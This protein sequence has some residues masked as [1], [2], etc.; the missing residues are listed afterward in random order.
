[1]GNSPYEKEIEIFCKRVVEKLRPRSV[2]LFGSI[3]RR[4]YGPWS[5]VDIIVISDELPEKFLER[6]RV[7]SD[8]NPTM[9]PIEVVGYTPAE[10]LWMIERRH[11]TALY[12]VADG[13]PLY[14]NGFFADARRVFENVKTKFD[15]VRIERGW[16][17]RALTTKASV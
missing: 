17:A 15:L 10:F 8:L 5:D 12:A 2:I 7:L 16:D 11:P 14:D 3:A 13:K 1:M 9:A 6:I 4:E